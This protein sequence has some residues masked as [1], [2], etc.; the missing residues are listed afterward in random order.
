[1]HEH[2]EHVQI[3]AFREQLNMQ[4]SSGMITILLW[5]D[6]F[7]SGF[8]VS[9]EFQHCCVAGLQLHTHYTHTHTHFH[10]D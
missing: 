1:M 3:F 4:F 2:V 10:V 7:G 6:A 5:V 8:A 9:I